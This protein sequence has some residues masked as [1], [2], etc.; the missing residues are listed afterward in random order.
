[1]GTGLFSW[2]Y[3]YFS[4]FKDTVGGTL[5]KGAILSLA[6]FPRTLLMAGLKLIPLIW[7]E[8]SPS[9][10]IYSLWFWMFLGGGFISYLCSFL[11]NP[12]FDRMMPKEEETTMSEEEEALAYD[13]LRK[14]LEEDR[15]AKEKPAEIED[16]SSRE[17]RDPDSGN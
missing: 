7:F 17:D 3:P 15:A 1:V 5:K 4:R 6:H 14:T 13:E 12:V 16:S 2:V 10:L 8:I 9:S 11:I